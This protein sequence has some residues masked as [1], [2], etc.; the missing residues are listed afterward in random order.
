MK[1]LD[2]QF[3]LIFNFK[4]NFLAS[5]CCFNRYDSRIMY[6]A[7]IPNNILWFQ[8]IVLL[9]FQF[10]NLLSKIIELSIVY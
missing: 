5:E 4:K 2:V 10:V 9:N 1:F 6:T 7:K 8:I 3:Q